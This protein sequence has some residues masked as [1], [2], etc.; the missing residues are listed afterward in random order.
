MGA[1]L[2]DAQRDALA[3]LSTHH[4]LAPWTWVNVRRAAAKQSCRALARLA[5]AE[6]SEKPFRARITASGVQIYAGMLLPAKGG[7]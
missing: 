6:V 3:M 1:V 2:T 7:A 4:A 5:L